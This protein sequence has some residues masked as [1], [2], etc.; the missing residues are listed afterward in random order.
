VFGGTKD[1][2]KIEVCIPQSGAIASLEY[3]ICR[4]SRTPTVTPTL[5]PSTD[6]TVSPSSPPTHTPNSSPTVTPT[7]SPSSSPSSSPSTSPSAAPSDSP[8]SS[9]SLPPMD[10]PTRSPN[11]P[12]SS[13]P[14]ASPSSSP[15]ASPSTSPSASPT[16][17]PCPYV[18]CDFSQLIPGLFLNR[19]AQRLKLLNDCG[20]AVTAIKDGQTLNVNVFNSSNIKNSN[21]KNDP[22]LGS[23]NEACPGG[24]P[25]VG[26]GGGPNAPFPNCI[27][28]NNL[29]IIQ[30]PDSPEN[31]PNDNGAG[32]C[33]IIE[34]QQSVEL[35]NM[36]LL[37]MEENNI[38]VLVSKF[39]DH[40]G[41]INRS[42][43]ASF[44]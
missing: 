39:I 18:V 32:G 34:F 40:H 37:D 35:V 28:Q 14:S 44:N 25:G 22:D 23:P 16:E 31:V 26:A 27:P 36:G 38:Q 24:G 4:G 19:E 15:S 7:A 21:P 3:Y 2:A 5:S 8:S 17:T 20:L 10:S 42:Y 12:P 1:V 30:S 29:L 33:F 13:S 43:H 6:P 41:A 11:S 9:P